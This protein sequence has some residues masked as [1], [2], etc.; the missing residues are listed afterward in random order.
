VPLESL[1]SSR[2]GQQSFG[3][4]PGVPPSSDPFTDQTVA[5]TII[6][7]AVAGVRRALLDAL[8][9]LGVTVTTTVDV[10]R[11]A[12]EATTDLQAA[13]RLRLLGEARQAPQAREE[14]PA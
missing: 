8:A 11:L 5:G 1:L 12:R 9:G 3:W 13:P 10:S 4:S 14:G 6:A 2:D 7:P